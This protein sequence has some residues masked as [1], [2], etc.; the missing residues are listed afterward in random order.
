MFRTIALFPLSFVCLSLRL[1]RSAPR[2]FIS[3]VQTILRDQNECRP[4][5]TCSRISEITF[6]GVS[7]RPCLRMCL[8]F[9]LFSF[10]YHFCAVVLASPSSSSFVCCFFIM[11]QSIILNAYK[12]ILTWYF[13]F[14]FLDKHLIGCL[15]FLF[16]QV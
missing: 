13:V 3:S 15:I 12:R 5:Y 8:W 14:F 11:P 7:V 1:F 4:L 10:Y 9:F 2:A 16:I 6:M